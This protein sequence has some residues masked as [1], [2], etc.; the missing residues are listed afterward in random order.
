MWRVEG[1]PGRKQGKEKVKVHTQ[2]VA[3]RNM[4]F[5]FHSKILAGSTTYKKGQ[6]TLLHS[7]TVVR[8]FLL[9]KYI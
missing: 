1:K 6:R 5:I 4:A 8:Y 2:F 3:W 7:N 9:G